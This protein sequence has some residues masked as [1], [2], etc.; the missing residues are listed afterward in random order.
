MRKLS[1]GTVIITHRLLDGS[2]VVKTMAYPKRVVSES[3]SRQSDQFTK[4][5]TLQDVDV[6]KLQALQAVLDRVKDVLPAQTVLVDIAKVVGIST[7][8]LVPQA[9]GKQHSRPVSCS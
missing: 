3:S 4:R 2:V 5:R 9:N 1:H 6:V 8:K 7:W